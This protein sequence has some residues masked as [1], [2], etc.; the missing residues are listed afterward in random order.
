MA[1]TTST[2]KGYWQTVK[3]NKGRNVKTPT[4]IKAYSTIPLRTKSCPEQKEKKIATTA[5]KRETR[6]IMNF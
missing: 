3:I 6:P 5:K 1:R 2:K 4:P